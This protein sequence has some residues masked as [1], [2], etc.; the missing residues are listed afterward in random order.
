MNA[1]LL[2]C[3]F[4]ALF[5]SAS[6]SAPVLSSSQ[7]VFKLDPFSSPNTSN[8]LA[9]S[10]SFYADLVLYAKWRCPSPLG[11]MLIRYP[12]PDRSMA[13]GRTALLRGTT[14]ARK[15]WCRSWDVQLEGLIT[16]ARATLPG[17]IYN[18]EMLVHTG[19]LS[20]YK[21]VAHDVIA[22]VTKELHRFPGHRIVVTGGAIAS[23]AAL[24]LKTALPSAALQLYTFGQP[25]V[26]TKKFA[27]H[28]EDTI[29][30]DN[31]FRAVH[32]LDSVPMVPRIDYEH[33]ATEYWQSK[34]DFPLFRLR[35]PH[36]SVLKCAAAGGEDTACRTGQG[37]MP[38]INQFHP[39]YFG[40]TMALTP[41]FFCQ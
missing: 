19:F 33:F 2:P 30:V 32:K 27:R 31:I 9:V 1:F 22:T 37:Y 38:F 35:D 26:G 5:L 12:P 7:V 10:R 13:A 24:L 23:I 39:F 6:F 16:D 34:A 29:G 21:D 36:K 41:F 17:I 25:R 3:L 20:A 11:N 15:S 28:V 8:A 40:Q 18:E 4:P 14:N